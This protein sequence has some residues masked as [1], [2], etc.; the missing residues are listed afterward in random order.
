VAE[1][2]DDEG[3]GG[4]D[5]KAEDHAR[6][7]LVHGLVG[8]ELLE[9]VLR[10]DWSGKCF[11]GDGFAGLGGYVGEGVLFWVAW[12]KRAGGLVVQGGERLG[13]G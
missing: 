11:D 4:S 3:G 12:D 9:V 10:E 5:A 6:L 7:D 8:D 1:L 2:G 13:E